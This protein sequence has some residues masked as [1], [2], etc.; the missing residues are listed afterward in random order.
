MYLAKNFNKIKI[1]NT[2][3]AYLFPGQGSQFPGMGKELYDRSSDAQ[4]FFELANELLGYKITELMFEGTEEELKNTLV[5]Q[6]AIFLHSVITAKTSDD[7]KP[8]MA[9]GHSL[10][11]VSVLTAIDV[12]S[13]EQGMMLI[14]ARAQAMQQACEDNPSTMAAI[15]G[16]SNLE[17]E[18]V[19]AGIDE[20]VVP[21][22]YNC[23]GQLV[24]AGTMKGVEEACQQLE[25]A[26]ARRVVRLKVSGGFHS[27]LMEGARVTM[28]GLVD[29]ISFQQGIC[30]IYQNV[31]ALPSTKPSEIAQKLVNQITSP[32][33]WTQTVERMIQDGATEFIEC[34]PG[35]VLQGLVRK[36]DRSVDVSAL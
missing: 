29:K 15:L 35:K 33:R 36:I 13:F 7:F 9:A 31:D 10:G 26:G 17:V 14:S 16:M 19:C 18:K 5:A 30:P 6:P 4:K 21:A 24:I 2:M 25:A 34:G 27:D 3:K 23:P 1:S 12:L 32:V 22:N 11:E 8:D 28:T 20:L